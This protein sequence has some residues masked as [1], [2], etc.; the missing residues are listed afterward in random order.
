MKLL[1]VSHSCVTD[2]NQQLYLSLSR[3]SNV[4][5][6]LMIP[7]NWKSEYAKDI[8][9]P[10]MLPDLPFP[11]HKIEV[12]NPG[13]NNLYYYKRGLGSVIKNGKPDICFMD[14]EPWSIAMMQ[15][16]Y[17]CRKYRIPLVSY[18]KQNI[19]KTYPPP[20]RQIELAAYHNSRAILALSEEVV[21]VLR[22]KGYRGAAPILAHGCDLRLF[23]PQDSS[24]LRKQLGL[25]GVV[26]GYMGRIIKEKGLNTLIDAASLL[27]QRNPELPFQILIVGAGSAESDLKNQIERGGLLTQTVFT[28]VIPH[29]NAGSYMNCMDIFAL[30]SRTTPRWKEQFGRVIIEALACAVPVV[31]S[32]S[33]QIPFVLRDTEGGMVFH[34]GDATDLADKLEALIKDPTLRL[35]LG[36]HGRKIV[37]ERYTYDAVALQLYDIL[38]SVLQG[39]DAYP[40][41]FGHGRE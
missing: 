39:N 21:D 15:A 23:S 9:G 33:G 38:F 14:E 31:G 32:D 25:S 30:P 34:E 5:V 3:L 26:I 11:V 6:E 19:L 41:R 17:A 27:K 20:F 40:S 24:E 7:A 12:G 8:H 22:K 29:R 28:G 1:A 10:K 37:Q 18:T 2:V 4:S 13:N 36:N 16:V 35:E